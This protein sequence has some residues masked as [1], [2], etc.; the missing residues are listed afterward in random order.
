MGLARLGDLWSRLGAF[1]RAR[2]GILESL[3]PHVGASWPVLETSWGTKNLRGCCAPAKPEKKRA[4][5]NRI[6]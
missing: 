3:R 6:T 4:M 2:G 1:L 5:S